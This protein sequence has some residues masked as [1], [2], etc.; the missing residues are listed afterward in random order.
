M[1]KRRNEGQG[2]F[3]TNKQRDYY[4]YYDRKRH[5]SG[6]EATGLLIDDEATGLLSEEEATGLLTDGEG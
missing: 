2:G 3:I 6:D 1:I 4:D 5:N